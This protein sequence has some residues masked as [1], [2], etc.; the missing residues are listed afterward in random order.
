MPA[1]KSEF[2]DHNR[3][4]EASHSES[5][6]PERKRGILSRAPLRVSLVMLITIVTA[7]GLFTS[8][9]V[10]TSILNSFLV[11]RV[12]Q[13]LRDADGWAL[14]PEGSQSTWQDS[15]GILGSSAP[16]VGPNKPPTD[17]VVLHV[18]DQVVYQKFNSINDSQPDV[19]GLLEPSAPR[20][21][22]AQKGSAS[23][24][25]WRATSVRN[26]DGSMTIVALP[27]SDENRIIGRLLTLQFSIG[28][29][30]LVLLIIFSMLLVRRAL[31]PLNEVE[32]TASLIAQGQ[33]DQ[34]VPALPEHTEV[35]R[36]SAALNRMLAQIQYAFMAVAGSEKAARQSEK[37]MRRFIGDASHELRTPLTSV[38]GYAEL[39]QSG[40]TDNADMVVSKIS[41]E[42]GRMSLL[43][44]DL[45]A[46]VRMD[47]GRPLVED[48]VDMLE[49]VLES[50]ESARAAFP[51][52]KITV[53]NQS[54]DV[55]VV[56]GDVNR[57]HQVVGNL[58]T[59]SLRHGGEE[60]Q[61]TMTLRRGSEN[62]T[63]SVS[64]DGVG[65]DPED[66]PHLFE[67]FYR[68]DTSRS[69]ASGGSG[70]G[71]SIVK[72]LV[73]S[74]GGQISVDSEKGAGTTFRIELP[75]APEE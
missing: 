63:L 37:S 69:R 11:E 59:N 29:V 51:G 67:R 52:R 22:P 66:L 62:V 4:R 73:E 28:A 53:S 49:L 34:R 13:E 15:E 21:V 10:V 58:L 24:D 45:L 16:Q 27:L 41:E 64:D 70:L 7:A 44:E 46:L 1:K 25:P 47:E 65:I 74:H 61:V 17:F 5:K 71:L 3:F 75:A 23:S 56:V 32:N 72:G 30:V 35:G 40:A 8:S 9:V 18:T 12:D 39:Y 2:T 14:L 19:S 42:A 68:A 43:V 50:A 57:L 36:L 26:G 31:K 55:P 33:L 38:R 48:R 54:G 60:A 20:T 6:K